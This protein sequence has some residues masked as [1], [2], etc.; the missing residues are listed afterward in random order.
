MK[1]NVE[2]S[3]SVQMISQKTTTVHHAFSLIAITTAII[4]IEILQDERNINS[5]VQIGALSIYNPL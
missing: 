4:L 1:E 3:R 5:V 2:S